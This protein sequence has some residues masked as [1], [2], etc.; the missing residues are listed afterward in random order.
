MTTE[1]LFAHRYR[2]DRRIGVGGM[3]TV[4]LAFDTRL[5]RNVAVKLLAEHLA[6]DASFVSRFRREALAAARL[7]H[8][9]IV[10][11]FDFGLDERSG[12]HYIVMELVRGQSGAEILRDAGV[13]GVQEALSMVLQA[14]RGLDY[15]HRNGVVHRDVK[16]GNLL[17]SRDNAVK[18]ADFGIAKAAEQSDITKA[19]SVLGTAAYLSP[20]QAR[21]E[22]AG[23]ASDLYALGVVA[24]Q[25]LAGRLP[26]DAASLTDLARLQETS[27]PPRLDELNPDVPSALAEAVM[28]ALHR[29]PERRYAD[30][31][32]METALV[33]A[34]QGRAPA[35]DTES[36]WAMDD[37]EATRMLAGTQ[38]TTALPPRERPRRRL[39]PIQEAP[40][41]R[42]REPAAGG[43]AAVSRR[44]APP[45]A[46]SKGSGMKMWLVLLLVLALIAG[47]LALYQAAQGTVQ[48][49]VQ[50]KRDVQG[51]VQDAVDEVKGLIEDNTR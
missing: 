10:Q 15:A 51:Q 11:V 26:Y 2:L 23:P 16:P 43:R 48:Q 1:E 20:E 30:A 35:R 40:P 13:L 6:E 27:P 32:D 12:R 41:R 18:L 25:L 39:E 42:R 19:G 45:P 4:Q 38:A 14:C 28:V 22:P 24:Y 46:R 21:G 5:E 29:D 7:V 36:T 37:T 33:D 8:P 9:N 3:S 17:R 49:G 44:S 47:G 34:L 31:A 50:L